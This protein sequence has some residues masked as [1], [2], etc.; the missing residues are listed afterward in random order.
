[1]SQTNEQALKTK[2]H[3]KTESNKSQKE[4]IIPRNVNYYRHLLEG[5]S[6]TENDI[7]WVLKLRDT[8]KINL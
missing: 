8:I 3:A 7:N 1:M 4:S 5:P 2:G 6:C